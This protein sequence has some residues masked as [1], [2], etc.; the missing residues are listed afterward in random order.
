MSVDLLSS[1]GCRQA[2]SPWPRL[3]VRSGIC[4][5]ALDHPVHL[6]RVLE[7][8]PEGLAVCVSRLVLLFPDGIP[9]RAHEIHVLRWWCYLVWQTN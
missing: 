2:E 8:P 7:L 5:S 1:C 9:A 4:G 6:D 3:A